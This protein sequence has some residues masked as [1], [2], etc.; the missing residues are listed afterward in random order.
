MAK[1]WALTKRLKSKTKLK[2]KKEIII[3]LI[4]L[5]AIVGLVVGFFYLKGINVFKEQRKFYVE[6]G[7]VSGLAESNAVTVNGFKI[8]LVSAIS[9]QPS[10]PDKVLIE[11]LIENKDIIIPEDTKAEL[12]SDLLGTRSIELLLGESTTLAKNGGF[13]NG[14]TQKDLTD[15]VN[16]QL[17]PLKQKTEELIGNLDTVISTVDEIFNVNKDAL[18]SSFNKLEMAINT[19]EHMSRNLDTI[20]AEN[21]FTF[22]NAM[23]K[24]ESITGNLQK[25]NEEVTNTLENLS[26]ITDSIKAADLTQTIDNAKNALSEAT[27]ILTAI[28]SQEGSLGQL[29]YNDSLINNVNVMVDQAQRLVENIKDHPNRYLQFA[30]FGSKDKGMKLDSRDEKALRRFIKDS[31][32]AKPIIEK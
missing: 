1:K 11:L 15:Q 32:R 2:G 4:S 16:E 23:N 22:R 5:I 12:R 18:N 19:F 27:E 31:L 3:G 20:V 17:L 7:S 14:A 26:A 25:S 21:R 28:N 9:F 13:I 30:V 10:K 29:I 8:G 24:V 6:Y